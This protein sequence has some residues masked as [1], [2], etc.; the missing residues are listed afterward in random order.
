MKVRPNLYRVGIPGDIKRR[1]TN[2]SF[3]PI[4]L[5]AYLLS[6]GSRRF[7]QCAHMSASAL[8]EIPAMTGLGAGRARHCATPL[9]DDVRGLLEGLV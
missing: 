5:V 4:A 7:L 2:E 8:N 6:K 1:R 3:Q 9:D